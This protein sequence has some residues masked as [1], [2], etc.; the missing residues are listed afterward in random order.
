MRGEV[1]VVDGFIE[2]EV[3]LEAGDDVFFRFFLPEMSVFKGRI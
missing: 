1:V 2:K 3:K